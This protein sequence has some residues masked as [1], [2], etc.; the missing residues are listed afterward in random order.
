MSTAGC[1]HF[2]VEQG[3]LALVGWR[4]VFIGRGQF[5]GAG[6]VLPDSRGFFGGGEHPLIQC[7]ADAVALSLVFDDDEAD[8][9]AP[10]EQAK[11]HGIFAREHAVE[12]E[13]HVVVFEELGDREHAFAAVGGYGAG[14]GCRGLASWSAE[15]G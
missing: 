3:L 15:S 10:G 4:D 11:A 14:C 6:E 13:G 7:V 9:I 5:Q 8:E 1:R 12:D 2:L